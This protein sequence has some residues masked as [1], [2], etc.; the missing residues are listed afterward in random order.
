MREARMYGQINGIPLT[1]VSCTM[2]LTLYGRVHKSCSEDPLGKFLVK[3]RLIDWRAY[4]ALADQK[5][6]QIAT[7]GRLDILMEEEELQVN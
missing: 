2:L 1:D 5:G 6:W 3:V 4:R 7:G